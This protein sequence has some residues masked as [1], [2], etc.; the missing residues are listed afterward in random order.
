MYILNINGKSR[1][2]AS[3]ISYIT[4]CLFQYCANAYFTFSQSPWDPL[5]FLRY[6]FTISIGYALSTFF[7]TIIA[8]PLH[9][10]DFVALCGV[11]ISLPVLN[12]LLFKG[13]VYKARRKEVPS[14]RN[15]G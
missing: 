4:A 9:I 7:L 2:L 14:D 13:W 11:A 12:F 15:E 6:V 3:T 5:Q 1:L 8:P 10:P